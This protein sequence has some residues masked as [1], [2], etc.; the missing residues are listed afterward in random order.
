MFTVDGSSGLRGRVAFPRTGAW[1]ADLKIAFKDSE[2]QAVTGE[3]SA[4]IGDSFL[5]NVTKFSTVDI[6]DGRLILQGAHERAGLWQE[7]GHVRLVGGAGGL[8]KIAAAKHY[9][10]ATLRV[11]LGD[12]L[13]GAGEKLSPTSDPAVL[14]TPISTWTTVAIATG[15]LITQLLRTASLAAN[16]RVLPDGT[17][18][19]GVETWPDSG[20]VAGDDYQVMTEDPARLFAKL[21][22][23]VPLLL[24]GTTLGEGTEA[25]RVSYVEHSLDEPETRTEVW[26]ETMAKPPADD[27]LRAAVRAFVG[28][29]EPRIEYAAQFWATIVAQSGDR[30]DVK[31]VDAS[32]PPM[33]GVPLL[34]G[35]A[36]WNLSLKPGGHVLVGWGG[37][38]PSQSYVIGLGADVVAASIGI[39]APNVTI[40]VAK[41]AQASMMGETYRTAED[42]M[43]TAISTAF[44]T[45]ATACGAAIDPTTTQAGVIATG[46]AL[47]AAVTAIKAFQTTKAQYLSTSVRHS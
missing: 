1:T 34:A 43:L 18:W 11:V 32:R 6:D 47:T 46:V 37:A 42:A 23:E 26:F 19:V 5:S 36:Q 15:R 4:A 33:A 22:I 13:A 45:A 31:P 7:I 38:D 20:L 27:R 30:I 10:S 29:A 14:A 40:G 8:R 24:P 44:A 16:W 9:T 12:L 41:S 39:E 3:D 2:A 28:G 35:F 17:V 25:R 21:G